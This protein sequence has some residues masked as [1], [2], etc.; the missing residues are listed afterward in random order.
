MHG[1]L[2]NYQT[3]PSIEA[4]PVWEDVLLQGAAEGLRRTTQCV[5]STS[6][7]WSQSPPPVR[8]SKNRRGHW[9]DLSRRGGLRELAKINYSQDAR[10]FACTWIQ[11]SLCNILRLRSVV[12]TFAQP[13]EYVCHLLLLDWCQGNTYNAACWSFST[14]LLPL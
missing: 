4:H 6:S 8:L 2:L 14:S 7:H 9:H 11:A 13:P 10:T 12:L 1:L 5:I 3:F